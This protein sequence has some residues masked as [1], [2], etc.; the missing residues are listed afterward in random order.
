M[1]MFA[2]P[3]AFISRYAGW[4]DGATFSLSCLA[5]V[6]L[7][8]RLGFVT[9]QL[10]MY[11]NDTL[12]FAMIQARRLGAEGG[13]T[14]LRVVQLSLLG[15]VISN[16]LLGA[17]RTSSGRSVSKGGHDKDRD[18]ER[19][20]LVLAAERPG[21]LD[22]VAGASDD[23]GDHNS[24]GGGSDDDEEEL[25]LSKAGCFIWLTVV[26]VFISF[27]SEFVTDAIRG[28]SKSLGVP[29]PFLTTILLPIVGN[30]AEHAS[31]IVFAYKN[32]VE[33]ALG[34][35]VAGASNNH[36]CSLSLPL[37]VLRAMLPPLSVLA[38]GHLR[39][40]MAQSL[41]DALQVARQLA[42]HGSDV[43]AGCRQWQVPQGPRP[44]RGRLVLLSD[45]W[46]HASASGVRV[47]TAARA[48]N[49]VR[50][51][52][53]P[54]VVLAYVPAGDS[55]SD[56][57]SISRQHASPCCGHAAAASAAARRRRST[58]Q[59]Q[60][61]TTPRTSSLLLS[62]VQQGRKRTLQAQGLRRE[63][64]QRT[65]SLWDLYGG[66][67]DGGEAGGGSDGAAGAASGSSRGDDSGE[68]LPPPPRPP[69]QPQIKRARI[70]APPRAYAS[71]SG[72]AALAYDA[73]VRRK[74]GS[75]ARCN[76]PD[77]Q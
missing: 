30:A 15:S 23:E 31:A 9:E 69:Q 45:Y 55:T 25:I 14:Y 54:A 50:V 33:I 24:K 1:L 19:L 66:E 28:A 5:L 10:A 51:I 67:I 52:L 2:L 59:Q 44:D 20:P 3:F 13:G 21:G 7:A 74:Y 73:A 61:V 46:Q 36:T 48:Q 53:C 35:A 64:Q 26:T 47:P 63:R 40:E 68:Q 29:M 22:A 17:Q 58:L 62:L 38:P 43:R 41:I 65:R 57:A 4:G 32:R 8:E 71:P 77:E 18:G 37:A 6:P 75:Q 16:L 76:F 11:T 49:V 27:L 56:S 72:H 70:A 34:V 12:A 42:S 39:R 60:M